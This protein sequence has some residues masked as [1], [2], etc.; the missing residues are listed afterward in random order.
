ME[1]LRWLF[2]QGPKKVGDLLPMQI[3]AKGAYWDNQEQEEVGLEIQPAQH[4][5]HSRHARSGRLLEHRKQH[6]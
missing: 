1:W 2:P 4:A 5:A 6:T 3:D